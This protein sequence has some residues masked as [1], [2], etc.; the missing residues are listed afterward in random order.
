VRA[1][2]ASIFGRLPIHHEVTTMK[3][4]R[5]AFFVQSWSCASALSALAMTRS[6]QAQTPALVSETDPQAVALGYKTDGTKTDAKKYPNYS[7]SQRCEACV[8]FQGKASNGPGSCAVFGNQLV[9]SKGWCSAW[10]KKV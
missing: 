3:N 1:V 5:R 4:S 2:N 10:T 6:A 7:A 8:L 9:A